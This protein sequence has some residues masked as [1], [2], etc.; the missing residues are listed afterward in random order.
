MGRSGDSVTVL[1]PTTPIHTEPA[2]ITAH[3]PSLEYDFYSFDAG[4]ARLDL[5]CLPTYAISPAQGAR[6]AVSIDDGVP[7]SLAGKG[8]DVLA[9]LRRITTKVQI[10]NPGQ[11]K[12]VVWM[13]DPGVVLDKLVIDFQPP[14]ESYLGPPESFCAGR[15]QAK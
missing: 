3:S 10:A 5:D 8:G 6:V 2:D 9:N 12:L 4:E 11:H 1:P 14:T 15:M 13:V 7:E